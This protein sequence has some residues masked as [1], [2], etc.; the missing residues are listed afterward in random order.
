VFKV[1]HHSGNIQLCTSGLHLTY[2]LAH[3]QIERHSTSM[4][5]PASARGA[6]CIS[7]DASSLRERA[8]K[9]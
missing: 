8:A 5:S 3:T 2:N 7:V 9:P 1:V 4:Y 6:I